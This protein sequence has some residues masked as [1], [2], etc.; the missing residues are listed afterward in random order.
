[1]ENKMSTTYL[2]EL[3]R[4]SNT[5]GRRKSMENHNAV[6]PSSLAKLVQPPQSSKGFSLH[7]MKRLSLPFCSSWNVRYAT[8]TSS[9]C[10]AVSP[11]LPGATAIASKLSAVDSLPGA[12]AWPATASQLQP[13]AYQ[14]LLSTWSSRFAQC[15]C[16]LCV[17]LFLPLYLVL[18]LGCLAV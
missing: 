13:T 15:W 8:K 1:M 4:Q 14:L 3:R 16:S 5:S 11:S 12:T 10:S 6:E 18:Q 7:K 17:Q 9:L 2:L